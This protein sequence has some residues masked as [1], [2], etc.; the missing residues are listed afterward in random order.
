MPSFSAGKL[1]EIDWDKEANKYLIEGTNK[2]EEAENVFNDVYQKLIHR[3]EP[4]NP[5]RMVM[6]RQLMNMEMEF[7]KI[8]NKEDWNKQADKFASFLMTSLNNIFDSVGAT[9][10]AKEWL[11]EKDFYME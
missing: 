2:T 8:D 10:G 11:K 1:Q 7:E 5:V 3:F 9:Q 4:Q 6:L